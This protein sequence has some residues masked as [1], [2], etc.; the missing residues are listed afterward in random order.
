VT[1]EQLAIK[2][3]KPDSRILILEKICLLVYNK[4][5]AQ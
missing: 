5:T 3:G 2:N 4:K 1:N